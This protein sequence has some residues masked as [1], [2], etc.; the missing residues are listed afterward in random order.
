VLRVPARPRKPSG[1]LFATERSP[2]R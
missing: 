1:S 2:T